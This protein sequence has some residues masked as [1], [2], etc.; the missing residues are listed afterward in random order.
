M[1]VRIYFH[2]QTSDTN[3]NWK[4]LKNYTKKERGAGWAVSADRRHLPHVQ[5]LRLWQFNCHTPATFG[6]LPGSTNLPPRT[7]LTK[8]IDGHLNGQPLSLERGVPKK[9][10]NR[11]C[12]GS[13]LERW[14][15]NGPPNGININKCC[16]SRELQK[17][18]RN[19][20]NIVINNATMTTCL[21]G[22]GIGAAIGM[23]DSALRKNNYSRLHLRGNTKCLIKYSETPA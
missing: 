13:Q 2:F 14:D 20:P 17:G 15:P 12:R 16:R 1:L 3:H 9:G 8:P 22:F 7:L 23:G 18:N 6:Q 10:G 21:R 19:I 4:E 5:R 11:V